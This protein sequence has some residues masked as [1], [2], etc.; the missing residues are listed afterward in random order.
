ME[1]R[2]YYS[3]GL[4]EEI[5]T[6]VCEAFNL[7]HEELTTAPPDGPEPKVFV[8]SYDY[9]TRNG[10]SSIPNLLGIYIVLKH[11]TE[12]QRLKVPEQ[13]LLDFSTKEINPIKLK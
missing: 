12:C 6:L 13:T 5:L 1:L 3:P 11:H 7:P 9:F 10:I 8:L 4:N 2:L